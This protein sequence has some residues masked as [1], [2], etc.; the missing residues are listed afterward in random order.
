[1]SEGLAALVPTDLGRLP[2]HRVAMKLKAIAAA[3]KHPVA[4]AAEAIGVAPKTI[5]GWAAACGEGG[6]R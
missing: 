5:W 3:T 2:G 6:Q 1:M 4:C